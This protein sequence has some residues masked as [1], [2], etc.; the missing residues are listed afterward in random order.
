MLKQK[1]G[2]YIYIWVEKLDELTKIVRIFK[3]DL[4][5]RPFSYII[6]SNTISALKNKRTRIST[7]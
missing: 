6:F 2:L 3:W 7:N 1:K 5:I 4:C